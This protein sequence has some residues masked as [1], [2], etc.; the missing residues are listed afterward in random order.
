[1]RTEEDRHNIQ[2][3]LNKLKTWSEINRMRFNAGNYKILNITGNNQLHGSKMKNALLQ[4][5]IEN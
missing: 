5:S 3:D 1:M 4:S 2:N